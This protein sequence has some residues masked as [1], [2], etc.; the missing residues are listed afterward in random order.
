LGQTIVIRGRIA[1][2]VREEA[3]KL[4]LSVDEYIVELI[5]RE[6]DPRDRA[7]EYIKAAEEL[8]KE[9][10]E[11]L[12]KGSIR[13][14]AEKLWR[15]AALAIKAYASWKEGKRLTSHGEL[16]EW[17][18]RLVKELGEWIHSAWASASEMHICFYEGWCG[19]E[20]VEYALK[21]IEKLVK[22]MASRIKRLS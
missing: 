13:Q 17:K 8:L 11:E 9:A 15:A 20:D 1:E 6:L 7:I 18:R 4:G 19:R 10:R 2:R 14:A 3:E 12:E 16:W 5:S 21:Q 22:E